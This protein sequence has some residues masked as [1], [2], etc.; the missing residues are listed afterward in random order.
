MV[1]QLAKDI[2]LHSA[3]AVN[4]F[5]PLQ[6][7]SRKRLWHFLRMM[8]FRASLDR[9]QEPIIRNQSYDTPLPLAYNDEDLSDSDP[10][11]QP[12][13]GFTDATF[14]RVPAAGMTLTM[15][16]VMLDTS[17]YES[18]T[19]EMWT[20]RLELVQQYEDDIRS[21]YFSLC[22]DS[23]PV[24]WMLKYVGETI[25]SLARLLAVRP[26]SRIGEDEVPSP[27]ETSRQVLD[28]ALNTLRSESLFYQ[29]PRAKGFQWFSWLQ[30]YSLALA[31]VEMCANPDVCNDDTAFNVVK[32]AYDLQSRM[33]ADSSSGALWRPIKK[34]MTRVQSLRKPEPCVRPNLPAYFDQTFAIEQN[35]STTTGLNLSQPESVIFE[36]V[37][38]LPIQIMQQPGQGNAMA[39]LDNPFFYWDQFI[40]DM[41]SFGMDANMDW[42]WR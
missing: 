26:M 34:L 32:Q 28:R 36:S 31:L 14:I 38:Q 40:D 5:A 11:P 41:G 9:G 18:N 6:R 15:K 13:K 16:L 33:I 2:G 30:W 29:D 23:I 22:D 20:Q 19:P 25:A 7:E 39:D 27:P 1:I 8:D 35:T 3:R 42:N 4:T 12:R 24:H 21:Q 10:L 17:F 37:T